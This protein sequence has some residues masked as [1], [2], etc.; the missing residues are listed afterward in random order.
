MDNQECLSAAKVWLTKAKSDIETARILILGSDRHCDTGVY[1]CQQGAEKSLKALL[2]RKGLTFPKT[3]QLEQLIDLGLSSYP[4]L[5]QFREQAE[6]LTPLAT[7]FRYP[8][9]M[10]EPSIEDALAALE[11]ARLIYEHAVKISH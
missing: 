6:L 2:C 7:E 4:D 11:S 10:L 8:G 1:H 9:D 3:H 5:E